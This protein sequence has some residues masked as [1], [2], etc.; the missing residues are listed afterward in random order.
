VLT[1]SLAD[2][3]W[4]VVS[5]AA[6][7]DEI[8]EEIEDATEDVISC[9]ELGMVVWAELEMLDVVTAE[10]AVSVDAELMAAAAEVCSE[11]DRTYR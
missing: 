3:R 11:G 8:A 5:A 2:S 10:A 7:D 6:S 9:D 1:T 4:L